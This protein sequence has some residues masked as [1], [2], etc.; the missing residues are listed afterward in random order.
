MASVIKIKRS[1]TGGQTPAALQAGELAINLV[2]KKLFSARANGQIIGVSGDQYD[3]VQSGNSTQGTITLTVDNATLSNDTIVIAGTNGSV[4]SGNSTQMTVDTTTYA[5][6][7]T[8]NSTIGQ[9]VMTPTGG[10]DTS[11]D[12]LNVVGANG[13]TVTGNSTQLTIT[14]DNDYDLTVGGTSTTGTIILGEPADSDTDTATFNGGNN[15]TVTNTS[16][17]AIKVSLDDVVVSTNAGSF[18][19]GDGTSNTTID[20]NSVTV[21]DGT[22]SVTVDV[23]NVVLSSDAANIKVGNTTAYFHSNTSSANTTNILNI[24]NA[25]NSTSNSTGALIVS[26]GAGFG[27][28]VTIGEKLTVHGD[29]QV[30][31]T[32]T[33]ISST[34]VTIDDPMLSMADNQADT[35]SSVDSVDV[36]MYGV[37]GNNTAKVF[38][39]IVRDQSANSYVVFNGI[40][41]EPSTTVTY[42]AANSTS[43]GNLGQLDAIIDGG[44]Y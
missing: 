5:V 25:S 19:A 29:L 38:H 17:S 40:T 11:A 44:S 10:G 12:T 31:G 26:G 2:D 20:F 21:Q 28:S 27:K 18:A 23:A 4:V 16:T 30:H 6:T 43:S 14:N 7:T 35:A 1:S 24:S 37:Y 22:N 42:N 34:T 9:I 32:T 33:S 39:G 8:G 15:I 41:S 3:V 36:G 13:V